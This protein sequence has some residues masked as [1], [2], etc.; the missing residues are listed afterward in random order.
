[1]KRVITFGT[2][3][4]LHE[5]HLNILRRAKEFGDYLIVGVSS[6]ELNEQKNKRC[7]MPLEQRLSIVRN[8]SLV[9]EVF[10]EESL[11][12]KNEYITNNCAHLLVMGDDW[13]GKFDWVDCE[14]IYLSRTQ[15][16]STT[17]IKL[18]LLESVPQYRILFADYHILKHAHCADHY[19]EYLDDLNIFSSNV[20]RKK[21][22]YPN[23]RFDGIVVFNKADQ[24]LRNRYP[25]TPIFLFDHGASNLKWFLGDWERYR[26]CDYFLTAGPDHAASMQ[27]YFGEDEAI[28]ATAYIKSDVLFYPP[29]VSREELCK[30]Y[31][32]DPGKRIILY[33]PTW[34]LEETND[35]ATILNT[36][37]TVENSVV[38][39]HVEK[40]KLE[41]RPGLRVADN[42]GHAIADLIKHSEVVISDTSS[43]LYEAAALKKKV[44]Q[45]LCD[46]Y[47]NNPARGYDY[48]VTEGTGRLFVCGLPVRPQNIEWALRNIDEYEGALQYAQARILRGSRIMGNARRLITEKLISC[49]EGFKKEKPRKNDTTPTRGQ[50]LKNLVLSQNGRVIVHAGGVIN[51]DKYTNSKE[52]L[53]AS[54]RRA[55]LIE[56]DVVECRDGLIVAHDGLE[57]E[58]GF[59]SG[60]KDITVDEFERAAFRSRYTTMS[61]ERAFRVVRD[62]DVN[63]VLDLKAHGK[64]YKNSIAEIGALAQEEGVIEKIVPQVYSYE[65]FETA[66]EWSFYGC[67]VSLWKRF[68][69]NPFSDTAIEEL[70]RIFAADPYYPIGIALRYQN[71]ITGEINTEVPDVYKLKSFGVRV[72]VHAQPPT[73]EEELLR[74]NFGVFAHD[75]DVDHDRKFPSDF[76]WR[77]YVRANQ[78][79]AKKGV[80]TEEQAKLHWLNHGR[81]E[82]RR[83]RP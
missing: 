48:P 71:T 14:T 28:L 11:E 65:D 36:L 68:D 79:L 61:V 15:G 31:G 3:D 82:R 49:I 64:T 20:V 69:R 17:E 33:A 41:A 43:V 26:S 78:D 57:S 25:E 13:A 56:L 40:R 10:V 24:E 23:E 29:T 16:I 60:F 66:R 63:L 47:S 75:V 42:T 55:S 1:M 51:G 80:T 74:S 12:R 83:Y 54:C 19:I 21:G 18:G 2:F 70:E 7:I 72:Y 4:M 38:C 44:I 67:I 35:I 58:Y 62:H 5:G 45:V 77:E 9:D 81:F 52:A 37:A 73:R 22:N 39:Q 50:F 6:D 27:S 34:L 76:E 30:R 59:K 8:L 32:L 53:E 46:T